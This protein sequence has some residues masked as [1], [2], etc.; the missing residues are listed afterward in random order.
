M[1]RLDI[2]FADLKRADRRRPIQWRG[3]VAR[4]RIHP[5]K[6]NQPNLSNQSDRLQ[7]VG[8]TSGGGRTVANPRQDSGQLDSH[9]FRAQRNLVRGVG[10]PNYASNRRNRQILLRPITPSWNPR[11]SQH[12]HRQRPHTD[13]AQRRCDARVRKTDT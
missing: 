1:L 4:I 8:K 10:A 3:R 13:E 11:Q 12:H 7:S 5:P 6:C 9:A 2:F